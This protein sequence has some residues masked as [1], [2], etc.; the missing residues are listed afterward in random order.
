MLYCVADDG[1]QDQADERLGEV[2]LFAGKAVKGGG[3][4]ERRGGVGVP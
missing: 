2:C 3:Q 4:A 1:Q